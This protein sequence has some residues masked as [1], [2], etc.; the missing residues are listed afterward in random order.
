CKERL[1][2]F[3]EWVETIELGEETRLMLHI[4]TSS[5]NPHPVK[6]D[7]NSLAK[8]IERL[9]VKRIF[10]CGRLLEIRNRNA[11]FDA[12]IE[13]AEARAE[14]HGGNADC[15]RQSIER[16]KESE[17]EAEALERSQFER[18]WKAREEKY[19]QQQIPQQEIERRRGEFHGRIDYTRA[20]AKC[21]GEAYKELLRTRKFELVRVAV[22]HC[23]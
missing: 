21:V 10:V 13:A 11:N 14:E 2:K 7:W 8:Q 6:G 4:L 23:R 18:I 16:F 12:M 19:K 5:N 1:A 9:G 3:K 22:R 17:R 20:H 15:L